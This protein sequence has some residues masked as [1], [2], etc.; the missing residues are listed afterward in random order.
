[1]GGLGHDFFQDAPPC[2]LRTAFGRK[3]TVAFDLTGEATLRYAEKSAKTSLSNKVAATGLR[4]DLISMRRAGQAPAHEVQP[5]ERSLE[6]RDGGIR[7]TFE[8]HSL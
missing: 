5:E 8:E 1:M 7:R 3:R 2:K 4:I 6:V